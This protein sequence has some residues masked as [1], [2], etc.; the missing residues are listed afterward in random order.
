MIDPQGSTYTKVSWLEGGF[1]AGLPIQPLGLSCQTVTV[2]VTF[3]YPAESSQ[4]QLRDSGGFGT[5]VPHLT[6]F[7]IYAYLY[8]IIAGVLS[9]PVFGSVLHKR[10]EN[11]L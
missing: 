10:S 5:T 8:S 4:L 1:S 2:L 7:E 3:C 6:S 9:R 11:F